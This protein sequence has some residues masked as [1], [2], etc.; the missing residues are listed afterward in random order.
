MTKFATWLSSFWGKVEEPTPEV[1]AAL[2]TKKKDFALVEAALDALGYTKE[3][4]HA[5]LFKHQAKLANPPINSSAFLY[6][7][8]I[9]STEPHLS[10]KQYKILEGVLEGGELKAVATKEGEPNSSRQF[11]FIL[12]KVE[13]IL[14]GKSGSYKLAV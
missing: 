1:E 11:D 2:E 7:V 8:D 10:K 4:L 13:K 9:L 6:R 12:E 14:E 5:L 3:L